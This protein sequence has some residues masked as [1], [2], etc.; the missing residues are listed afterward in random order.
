MV[1][2]LVRTWTHT[3]KI[4]KR[5]CSKIE[6]PPSREHRVLWEHK[7]GACPNLSTLWVFRDTFLHVMFPELMEILVKLIQREKMGIL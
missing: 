2:D 4:M 5:L 7:K 1:S 6:V 3:Q